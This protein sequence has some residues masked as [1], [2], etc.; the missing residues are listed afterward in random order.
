MSADPY[1]TLAA[2]SDIRMVFE[3]GCD[4]MHW[5]T[6]TL[7]RIYPTATLHCFDTLPDNADRVRDT[8]AVSRLDA[9][10]HNIAIGDKSG[11]TR[12]W[13][14]SNEGASSSLKRPVATGDHPEHVVNWLSEPI[15][16]PCMTL[17][18]F[19]SEHN[20]KHVD[21]IHMDVQ[22]GED[23]VIKGATEMLKRTRY[24]FTEHNTGQC[25][26]GEPAFIGISALLTGWTALR[27]WPY[28]A[29]FRNDNILP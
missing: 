17:D 29:L 5:T 27:V 22:S 12:L 8:D 4:Y 14:A 16:V 28:D 25:Y 15:T 18:D 20:I 21:L 13:V 2:L 11:D 9:V 26:H 24:I 3:I 23:L 7:R 10:F 19:C 1:D 6:P